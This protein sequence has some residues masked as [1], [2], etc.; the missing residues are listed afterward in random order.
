MFCNAPLFSVESEFLKIF[1]A[2][3]LLTYKDE[4]YN[5]FV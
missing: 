2:S 5:H 3:Y 1:V 4:F